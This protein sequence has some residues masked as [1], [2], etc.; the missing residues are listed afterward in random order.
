MSDRRTFYARLGEIDVYYR[1]PEDIDEGIE[2]TFLRDE[3][4]IYPSFALGWVP[5]CKIENAARFND[6]EV[7]TLELFLRNNATLIVEAAVKVVEDPYRPIEISP[8]DPRIETPEDVNGWMLWGDD[9]FDEEGDI[10]ERF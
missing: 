3:V 8:D 7:R 2:V 10:Y 1:K 6:D 5:S 4:D 9:P